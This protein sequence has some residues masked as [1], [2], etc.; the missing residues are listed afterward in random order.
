MRSILKSGDRSGYSAADQQ[1]HFPIPT[2]NWGRSKGIGPRRRVPLAVAARNLPSYLD[3]GCVRG[4]LSLGEGCHSGSE[5]A[6]P[7]IST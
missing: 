2:D 4:T 1:N 3:R 6:G 7:K 5:A